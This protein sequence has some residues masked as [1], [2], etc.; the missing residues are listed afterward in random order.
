MNIQFSKEVNKQA[1]R[2]FPRLHINY[3]TKPSVFFQAGLVS[4][5]A[6]TL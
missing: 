1:R 5:Q 3:P 6:D 4:L 2:K